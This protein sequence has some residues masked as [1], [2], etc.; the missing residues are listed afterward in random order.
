[1][2]TALRPT[3][4]K[5]LD[6]RRIGLLGSFPAAEVIMPE[7]LN[8]SD[9]AFQTYSLPQ[10]VDYGGSEDPLPPGLP[11]KLLALNRSCITVLYYINLRVGYI[12][13]FVSMYGIIY[14]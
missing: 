5:H 6:L 4:H 14:R 3:D 12:G 2:H 11:L 10:R 8:K 13:S 7:A 9:P 1:M